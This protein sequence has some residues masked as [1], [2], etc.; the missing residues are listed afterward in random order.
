MQ[1]TTGTKGGVGRAGGIEGGGEGKG[2]G[3]GGFS[4][5]REG[6]YLKGRG[7]GTGTETT[8]LACTS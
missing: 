4:L 6:T 7:C 3:E 5:D 2:G 8:Q 1:R